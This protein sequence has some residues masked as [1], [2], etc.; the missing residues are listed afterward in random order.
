MRLSIPLA[1]ALV[2]L[3]ANA[4]VPLAAPRPKQ[5]APPPRAVTAPT[6]AITAATFPIAKHQLANGLTILTH[7]DHSVPTVTFWQWFKVGSRNEQPGITGISH[8]FEHMMFNGSKNVAPKEYDRILESNGG[9]SNAFTSNDQTAYYEDIASDRVG[10]LFELDSDRMASLSLLPDQLKSEIEVVKEE[11]R[12]RTDNSIPG[13]L[14][15]QL[16]ATAFVAG[17]YGWPVIGW[18]K[19]LERI[20]REDCVEYFRT[21]YAPNNCILVVAGHFDTKTVLA[22]IEKAFGS[23]PAQKPPAEPFDSEPE[24]RG[25]RRVN[26]LY[27]AEA[28]SF[29]IGYKAP[30]VRGDDVWVLDVISTILSRGESSRLHEALVVDQQI[31]LDASSY[32]GTRL[33]PGLF[34]FA[35]EM[36]P[37]KTAADGER[38]LQAV[39]DKFVKDGPTDRELQKA[40]NIL[41]ARFVK[42]LKTNNGVGEA[43]AFAEHVLGDYK[44]MY[45]TPERYRRVTAADVKRVAKEVFVSTRRTVAVLVP[46]SR[47]GAGGTP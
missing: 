7:E 40:K 28:E 39:L 46:E 32:F 12:L 42:G 36:R 25:E 17:P 18:M 16:Y 21:Y 43:I 20:T 35:V 10:V 33:N 47:E 1:L 19:D 45:E 22:Q 38:A 44:R 30:G 29:Q 26:V 4:A 13:M 41:E 9:Y 5:P 14:D 34:E 3:A 15:E 11:R 6:S 31:A 37:G 2:A 27:P 8:F 24:Q 23:I